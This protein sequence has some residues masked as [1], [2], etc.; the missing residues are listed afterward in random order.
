MIVAILPLIGALPGTS[1]V[2]LVAQTVKEPVCNARRPK[3][4]PRVGKMPPE[5]GMATHSSILAWR[6]PWTEEPRYKQSDSTERLTLS[7]FLAL[8]TTTGCSVVKP[9]VPGRLGRP[10]RSSFPATG[11]GGE[12]ACQTVPF[13][14]VRTLCHGRPLGAA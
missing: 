1:W 12:L 7:L 6:I 3:F 11:W 4:D 10:T 5:K 8:V 13:L 2:C 9:V 14:L